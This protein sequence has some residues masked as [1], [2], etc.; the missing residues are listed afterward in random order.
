MSGGHHHHHDHQHGHGHH[1]GHA[2]APA[3]FGRAFAIGIAL[4]LGFV[5]IEAVSRNRSV[6]VHSGR[7]ERGSLVVGDSHHYGAAPQPFASEAVDRLMLRHMNEALH[8]RDAQVVERWVGVY[9]SAQD[10]PC[11]VHAPD[12]ATRVVA[13]TGGSGASTAFGLA[14]EVWSAW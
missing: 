7:V 4:N 1:H 3:T 12:E 6:F 2:H 13:V 11:V 9:P 10:A 14:E 8:L 5:A